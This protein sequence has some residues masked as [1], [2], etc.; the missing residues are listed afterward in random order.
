MIK[1]IP[2][3]SF[4]WRSIGASGFEIV[5]K[6][7]RLI[8]IIVIA[9]LLSLAEFGELSFLLAT[10]G[11][12]S[13]VADM[14]L[15]NHVA[16][17][18][19]E[20]VHTKEFKVFVFL[21]VV[22]SVVFILVGLGISFTI[23]RDLL[24]PFFFL[25]FSTLGYSILEFIYGYLRSGHHF[26]KE[27]TYRFLTSVLL[28][29][30]V[31]VSLFLP[32]SMG[33]LLISLAYLVIPLIVILI[34][35]ARGNIS[36]KF[37]H[38]LRS[39]VFLTKKENLKRLAITIAPLGVASLFGTLYNSLDAAMLGWY[40]MYDQSGLYGLAV[41]LSSSIAIVGAV[42]ARNSLPTFSEKWRA[43]KIEE[44]KA[45]F[46]KVSIS[47]FSVGLFLVVGIFYLGEHSLVLVFSDTYKEA[48]FSLFVL[49]CGVV[50]NW[51]VLQRMFLAIAMNTRWVIVWNSVFAAAANVGLNIWL[52][53]KMGALGA[54]LATTFSYM[55]ILFLYSFQGSR[56]I[57]PASFAGRSL[58]LG[59]MIRWLGFMV[60]MVVSLE[61]SSSFSEGFSFW[62]QLG[63]V[64]LGL[65][66]L[67]VY[68]LRNTWR[69]SI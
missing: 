16:G 51:F 5:G 58:G 31:I 53:P 67:F 38:Y 68:F 48:F 69:E 9:R 12:V 57:K 37:S 64:S 2:Q 13:V 41:R 66:V 52:I 33:V 25:L 18:S 40:Q 47:F 19:V 23:S 42:L 61:I 50:L 11:M 43:G 15:S 8:G 55:L 22:L 32:F 34:I 28:P 27:A 60:A 6:V 30:L 17:E 56:F 4:F 36:G 24:I 46:H 59:I 3:G 45:F 54:A 26:I 14:G 7:L 44:L 35:L 49:S 65:L 21:K 1:A 63:L 29:V 39:V 10:V 20:S 62:F